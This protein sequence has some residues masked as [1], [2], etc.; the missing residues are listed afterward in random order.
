MAASVSTV[1]LKLLIEKKT[2]K[3]IFAEADKPF[4]D[5][6]FHLMSLPLGSVIKLVNHSS[7]VGSLGNLYGSI[8]NISQTYLQPNLNKDVL[9]NPKVATPSFNAPLLLAA[10]E[11]S[12]AKKFY[13]CTGCRGGY[14][15]FHG[16]YN[17]RR[18]ISD[19]PKAIC[20]NCKTNI[21]SEANYVAPVKADSTSRDESGG[22]FVKGVV[23]YMVTDDL[24]V[25][26]HSTI[27]TI[28]V[29][30][31]FN[32]KDFGSVEVKDV[33]LGVDEGLKVLKAALHTD[34]VLTAVF[35]GK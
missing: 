4:V 35:L 26:P 28:T 15:A 25:M 6:L 23:T 11:A 33:R 29:L 19:D 1:T 7:M 17:G 3:V 20:P 31:D 14:D 5:F 12:Q 32:I 21:S 24:K 16:G 34:S 9:L 2:Q 30:N 22:G 13:L 8:K 18:S 27:S 10:G